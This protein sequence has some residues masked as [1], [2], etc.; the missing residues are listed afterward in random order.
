MI[1]NI[2]FNGIKY[3]ANLNQ[4]LDISIPLQNGSQ[5]PGAFFIPYPVFEPLII[6]NF[7]GSI[8][9]GG[10]VNCFNLHLNPHGNGTHTE[11]VAHIVNKGYTINKC[12][13]RFNFIAQLISVEPIRQI[14]GDNVI[15]TDSI[16]SKFL[17]GVECIVVRTL[18]NQT[19]KLSKNYSGLNPVYFEPDSCHFM[20]QQNILHLITD[21]PSVDREE[22][23]G[24]MQSHRAFWQTDKS[25]RTNATITELAFIPNNIPD[26]L[27]L[28]NLQIASL[29]SDAS[30][31]KPVLYSLINE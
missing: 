17:H 27:Y 31:S 25:I 9:A 19:D 3:R 18:P 23:A 14:N 12:L 11:C 6:G 26:G 16:K 22:D 21:L 7:T 28:V 15:T 2:D 4:P 30:P 5:N 29:E 8:A 1:A 10:S 20:A 13:T 24:L